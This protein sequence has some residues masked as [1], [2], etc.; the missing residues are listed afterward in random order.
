MSTF[1][2]YALDANNNIIGT[3]VTAYETDA[4]VGQIIKTETSLLNTYVIISG[5]EYTDYGPNQIDKITIE[6]TQLNRKLHIINGDTIYRL[7]PKNIDTSF[8][9][10]KGKNNTIPSKIVPYSKSNITDQQTTLPFNAFYD[11]LDG[12]KHHLMAYSELEKY[13]AYNENRNEHDGLFF[14]KA[15]MDSSP[16]HI[17]FT[18]YSLIPNDNFIFDFR[19]N[20]EY[21]QIHSFEIDYLPDSTLAE[22]AIEEPKDSEYINQWFSLNRVGTFDL[23]LDNIVTVNQNNK[24]MHYD[25]TLHKYINLGIPVDSLILSKKVFPLWK[26]INKNADILEDYIFKT[27]DDSLILDPPITNKQIKPEQY[28]SNQQSNYDQK[29]CAG[30]FTIQD[31]ENMNLSKSNLLFTEENQFTESSGK[32]FNAGIQYDKDSKDPA[33]W[34]RLKFNKEWHYAEMLYNM[35]KKL[36]YEHDWNSTVGLH[37][38]SKTV[39]YNLANYPYSLKYLYASDPTTILKNLSNEP[40]MIYAFRFGTGINTSESIGEGRLKETGDTKITKIIQKINNKVTTFSNPWEYKDGLFRPKNATVNMHFYTFES[41]HAQKTLHSPNAKLPIEFD[42]QLNIDYS[43]DLEYKAKGYSYLIENHQVIADVS[44]GLTKEYK[45]DYKILPELKVPGLG[46]V[47]NQCKF[48]N[49]ELENGV[50]KNYVHST[51]I[52]K[53]DIS[54][55]GYSSSFPFT[56][57]DTETINKTTFTNI[58]LKAKEAY[59]FHINFFDPGKQIDQIKLIFSNN[60]ESSELTMPAQDLMTFS[61]DSDFQGDLQLTI[62]LK[63]TPNT[64]QPYFSDL[65]IFKVDDKNSNGDK[66]TDAE[67]IKATMQNS[68]SNGFLIGIQDHSLK[69]VIFPTAFCYIEDIGCFTKEFLAAYLPNASYRIGAFYEVN[70]ADWLSAQENLKYKGYTKLPADI[71][72]RHIRSIR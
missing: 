23:P 52:G 68:S 37:K 26:N 58:D 13:S 17:K 7:D 60:L 48:S 45:A 63:N 43:Y 3:I 31:L 28:Y 49:I 20:P 35:F 42:K 71:T 44:S 29:V 6:A 59:V 36:K 9:R 21:I 47:N 51:A 55:L 64:K 57:W 61:R 56:A 5:F 67:T 11:I 1:D 32:Q 53:K 46:F 30:Q 39:N 15:I 34:N 25:V 18:F 19:K 62:T 16:V 38:I 70:T 12:N 40:D 54:D 72:K 2:K 27:A 69:H 41:H 65:G 8:F 24:L 66:I 10:Y 33:I 14:I 22:I 4:A 50:A